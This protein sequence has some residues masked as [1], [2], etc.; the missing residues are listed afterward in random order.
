MILNGVD[1][2][3][4]RRGIQIIKTITAEEIQELANKYLQPD[5]FYELVVI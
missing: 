1:E 4:F 5:S 2:D 3:Y